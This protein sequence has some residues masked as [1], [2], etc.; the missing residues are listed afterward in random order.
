M[1]ASGCMNIS[2]CTSNES[3]SRNPDRAFLEPLD[4]STKNKISE[5]F[6]GIFIFKFLS[7]T[8]W[9]R[10]SWS[11]FIGVGIFHQKFCSE[12]QKKFQNLIFRSFQID[13][14]LSKFGF[15]SQ[16]FKISA[17][18]IIFSDDCYFKRFLLGS[19]LFRISSLVEEGNVR[20]SAE[21][22]ADFG[23]GGKWNETLE[24]LE[25]QLSFICKLVDHK[26]SKCALVIND[27]SFWSTW[28]WRVSV[29]FIDPQE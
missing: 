25:N 11:W 20:S 26:W 7:S 21:K 12:L 28:T 1:K 19:S 4:I 29:R 13:F 23:G 6:F 27:Q 9:F 14:F 15:S 16:F 18:I 3:A 24:A 5:I 22:M 10:F 8:I 17:L 2:A